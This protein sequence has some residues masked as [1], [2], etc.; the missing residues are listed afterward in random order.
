MKA[1]FIVLI[2]EE[3]CLGN[4]KDPSEW[5]WKRLDDYHKYE[6][7]NPRRSFQYDIL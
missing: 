3:Q 4:D 2:T 5:K 1:L 6:T 7:S